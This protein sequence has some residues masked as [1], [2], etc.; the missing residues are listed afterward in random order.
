MTP[1]PQPT[2]ARSGT[3]VSGPSGT[4]PQQEE[5]ESLD[6]LYPFPKHENPPPPKFCYMQAGHCP[7]GGKCPTEE[8]P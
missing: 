5:P 3:S 8:K 6:A 2:S 4:P 1:F 7:C